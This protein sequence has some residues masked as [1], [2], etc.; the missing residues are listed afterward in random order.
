MMA[1]TQAVQRPADARLLA[2]DSSGAMTHAARS[3]LANFL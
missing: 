1:A 3:S 2:I